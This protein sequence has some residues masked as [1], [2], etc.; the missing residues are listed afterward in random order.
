MRILIADKLAEFVTHSLES[1]GFAVFTDSSLKAD[2]LLEEMKRIDPHILIVRSTKINAAHIKCGSNLAL[3]I[4]AGAGI[5]TIDTETASDYGIYVAN[6]P[7]QNAIAVAELALGHLIN[8]DR[9]ISDNVFAL[10]AGQWKKKVF[11]KNARGLFGKTIAVIGTGSC[12]QEL[13]HRVKALGMEVNA[14]SRSL[15]SQKAEQLGVHFAS[16]P[17]DACRGA[18]ALSVHLAFNSYTEG[19]IG[20]AE[21]EALN[22]GAYVINTSRGGIIDENALSKAIERRGLL[23]GLDVFVGEPAADGPFLSPLSA[24]G[25]VY[26]THHIGASTEQASDAVG[27]AVVEII[28]VWQQDGIVKNCVNLAEK[29]PADHLISI[30]HVDKVG[31]LAFI[32][33]A[34]RE[35]NHNI[36]EMENIIFKGGRAACAQIQ[37]VGKP[38]EEMLKKINSSDDI[39]SVSYNLI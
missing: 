22:P 4:R 32:L 28:R 21:L 39:F 1:L 30:R 31:V 17:L 19:I 9:K 16:S 3:I 26:G 14:W 5:N 13:I 25:S 7:G 38:S 15:T 12:G 34:I 27:A 29:S 35:H 6:C 33:E 11:T 36:Q 24:N 18:D 10:R 37:I 20:E 2:S 23:A 8:L